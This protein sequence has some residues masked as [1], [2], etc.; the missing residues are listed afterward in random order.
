[1]IPSRPVPKGSLAAATLPAR[2]AVA[3]PAAR[4]HALLIAVGALAVSLLAVVPAT[5][6]RLHQT[7]LQERSAPVV[8]VEVTA[9]G[10]RFVPDEIHVPRGAL[11]RIVLTNQDPLSPHD[12]QTFGQRGDAR[13]IAWPGET[14]TATFSAADRPGRYA[15]L[16]TLR[17]HADAGMKGVIV[18]E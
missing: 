2:P 12:L 8:T 3:E 16:C 17:G 14:R 10:M 5:I 4:R 7:A 13:V 18:V 6:V 1:M 11:V 15:F 9:E